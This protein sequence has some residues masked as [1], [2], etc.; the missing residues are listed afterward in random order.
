M[1]VSI[2]LPVYHVASY[3]TRCLQSIVAQSYHDIE[4][5]VIDDCGTDESM[6]MVE[7]FIKNYQGGIY[8]SIIHHSH[9]Q[10]LAA[11]RNTGIKTA[12]SEYIY[13][14]DSDD[15]ITPDC[16]ETLVNI[17][18]ENPD[19]DYVQGDIVTGLNDLNDGSISADIPKYCDDRRLLQEIIL[20]KIHRTAWNKLIKRSFLIDNSLFFREGIQMEDH[21]WTYFIAKCAHAVSFVHKGTYYYFKNQDSITNSRTKAKYIERYSAYMAYTEILVND[22]LQR[23]DIQ[24][25]HRLYLG[26]TMV[27]CMLHLAPLHS[28]R[29]WWRFWKFACKT[30][31]RLRN[32]FT[33]QRFLL[34]ICMMPPFCLMAELNGWH[35]RMRQYVITKI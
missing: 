18:Q 30:A 7:Q 3:I 27:F 29:H 15:A 14:M 34:F 13:F 9:N 12:N 20:S 16:I 26:E 10:G 24:S 11:A 35:W 32:K 2:I 28:L 31:Y 17:A 33:W 23:D 8:F 1:K 4:C 5:I 6:Q 25:C 19:A 22:M 21:C